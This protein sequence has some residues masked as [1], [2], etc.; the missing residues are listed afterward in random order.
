MGKGSKNAAAAIAKN[1][2]LAKEEAREKKEESRINREIN[3]VLKSK[4]IVKLAQFTEPKP[5]IDGSI[6]SILKLETRT[7]ATG[8]FFYSDGSSP[9]REVEIQ[10]LLKPPSEIR[11]VH[12]LVISYPFG[13]C[14]KVI[15]RGGINPQK[16]N[17]VALSCNTPFYG[18]LALNLGIV[19]SGNRY[20][21]VLYG[22]WM[23]TEDGET[24]TGTCQFFLD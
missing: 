16:L 5:N 14:E 6:T 3:K 9:D 22:K 4:S 20:R 24:R 21:T 10:F 17:T 13:D 23:E 7:E 18:T 19:K 2:A 15:S 12:E 8:D 11:A 1:R